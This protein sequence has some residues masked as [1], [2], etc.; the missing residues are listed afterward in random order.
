MIFFDHFKTYDIEYLK[1]LPSN[2]RGILIAS[3]NMT[4]PFH[5][6]AQYQCASRI[7][8]ALIEHRKVAI[9]AAEIRAIISMCRHCH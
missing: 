3:L 4:R 8:D 2:E 6:R 1:G 9:S 5:E 7:L